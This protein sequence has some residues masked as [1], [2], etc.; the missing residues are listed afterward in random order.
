MTQP[1]SPENPRNTV[2]YVHFL[3]HLLALLNFGPRAILRFV[4]EAWLVFLKVDFGF[5]VGLEKPVVKAGSGN[6]FCVTEM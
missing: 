4:C 6:Y 3:V 2:V 1:N 5:V